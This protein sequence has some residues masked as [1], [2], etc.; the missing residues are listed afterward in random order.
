M[1]GGLPQK[2][3]EILA[4]WQEMDLY[5]KIREN[6]EGRE[7]W[8][9]HDGPP[10][11]NGHIHMGHAVNKIL[12]DVVVKSYS[13]LGYDTPYIPG[14][15]CHGLP[16]E[17]KI[18]EKYRK[19]GKDKDEVEPLKFRD[20]CRKFAGEWVDI[21]SE[22]FQRL[23]ISGDWKNPYLTMTNRAE[24]KIVREIHKFASNGGLYKGVKPVMWSTVEK[25]ALAEA[26]VE[27][28]EHKSITVWVRFPIVKCPNDSDLEGASVVIWTTTPWTLPSN[29]AV[30]F[31]S[32]KYSLY[33]VT[34]LE[35]DSRA[36]VGERILVAEQL[37]QDLKEKS[38]IAEWQK[39]KDWGIVNPV[40]SD[41]YGDGLFEGM[42][43]HHPL[44]GQGY[45]FD[46]P[47]L[48]G[49]FVT[50][51][52]GTGFV[53]IAP[54]HG[55]DD[56][57]LGQAN[58]I[59]I[60]DN[61]ADD[62][63]F[64]NHVPLFAGLE[65][66]TQEGKMGD[67]NFA[68]LKA[69]DEAGALLA[70]G[71]LRHEYPHSW[72]SGAPVIFRTTPQW[73][74]KMG[75][76]ITERIA[77]ILIEKE[78][79]SDFNKSHRL[80]S[81]GQAAL[82]CLFHENAPD[83]ENQEDVLNLVFGVV[84]DWKET[85]SSETQSYIYDLLVECKKYPTLRDK[86]LGGIQ[87]TRWVP[88]KGQSRIRAMIEQRPDWCISRQ[89]AWGVPI[90]LFVNKESGETLTDENVLNRIGDIFEEEGSDSWWSRPAQDFLGNDYKAEDFDQVFDIVDVWFES[91]ST[92]AFV[93]GDTK[94]WP[95]YE[96]V[97]KADLYLEGSDQHRGWFHSSLLESCGTREQAPYKTVLTHG[98]VLDEKGYKMSK[99]AGNV[100][101]PLKMME[102]YGADIL[103][104]WTMTS[105]FAED[106]RIGKDS[107]KQT[108]D[109]YRRIRNTLRFLL[110]ALDGFT[111][112]E[113]V[114]LKELK[115]LPEL[116][117]LVLHRLYEMDRDVREHIKNYEFL[118][119][120]KALHDFCNED[121]SAFYF[122]IRKDRLYCDRS[123]SF[124]RRAT[125]TVMAEIFKALSTWLAPILCFTAE[126]AWAQRPEGVFEDA[127][128]VHLRSFPEVP[129]EWQNDELATKWNEVEKTRKSVL[130]AI[131]PL[132]ASKE[133]GSSLEALPVV[134]TDSASVKSL[135][136]DMA[137]ICIT[138]QIEIKDGVPSVT[139]KKADGEKCLRCWKVLPEVSEKSGHLC[140]RCTEAVAHHKK[141]A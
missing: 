45:D 136:G 8:V 3:P 133:L 27:Y 32:I 12:K 60:T 134:T 121:L 137:D 120:A 82:S 78:G 67:G 1:R 76:S 6:S 22:E 51:E 58:D 77:N 81:I 128:S 62:G 23:G 72:R 59:E 44:H 50:E 97:D 24:G 21:Q 93:V 115:A 74:I 35:P 131:E 52:A 90:A 56:F 40:G 34:E 127:E 112:S 140:N 41:E 49:D 73:F 86:S 102:Q 139:I 20:E 38:K 138:S 83:I 92:H 57:Y 47:A 122:D 89:R 30:A 113:S 88:P 119:L 25:T 68:V 114:D 91:G 132:R 9:L 43:C 123:D 116:E 37:A 53:H 10:Y 96:G 141:A 46:V 7:K 118:K 130:E 48:E 55:Q 28:K 107:L 65:V 111:E 85:I 124:E 103:R 101:D 104:L 109:L 26:E 33:K 98:F 39:I 2:E 5:A 75:D 61:V 63:K 125:R 14:W 94:T 42:I 15:D 54:G 95:V 105:D 36:K 69:L 19:D 4:K 108:A 29:R 100:V 11:A 71:S 84:D 70:K 129:K 16:I 106:I 87:A 31:G 117:Q 110:G 64:R 18:E 99:S 80:S 13:M 126:E 79:Y 17:W 66:Y 135:A